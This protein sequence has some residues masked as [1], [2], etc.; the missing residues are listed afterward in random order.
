MCDHANSG[1]N[2][3][4]A[5]EQTEELGPSS[6]FVIAFSIKDPFGFGEIKSVYCLSSKL[7]LCI[8]KMMKRSVQTW[9]SLLR[10][11]HGC[12][13]DTHCMLHGVHECFM[14]F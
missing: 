11:C 12:I 8:S 13:K 4:V 10:E 2:D 1:M 5:R 9:F 7:I 3:L 6:P 14:D